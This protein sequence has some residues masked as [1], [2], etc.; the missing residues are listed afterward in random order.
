M[1]GFLLYCLAKTVHMNNTL[2]NTFL[3]FADLLTGRLLFIFS[4]LL[5]S[6]SIN[7]QCWQQVSRGPNHTLAIA[8]DGS[9]W[10]WGYNF[11]GQLGIGTTEK[12]AIPVKVG[13]GTQWKSVSAGVYHT[14]A[15]KNDGTLWAWGDNSIGTLGDSNYI[16]STIPIQIGTETNWTNICSGGIHSL[17]IK[18]N[19][20]LWGWGY[21]T[22]S[23]LTGGLSLLNKVPTQIGAETDWKSVVSDLTST[24][25]IKT[26]GTLWAWGDNTYGQLGLGDVF[27]PIIMIPAKV[28]IATDWHSVVTTR[29]VYL[30]LKTDST[31]WGW[32][33]NEY[34][35]LGQVSS[36]RSPVLLDT[37][38]QKWRSVAVGIC[39]F[40]VKNDGTLWVWGRNTSDG[41]IAMD[42]TV[43]F[44]SRP[45]RVGS[46]N[47]WQSVVTR[48]SSSVALTEGNSMFGWGPNF[49]GETGS[50]NFEQQHVP[51]PVSCS[52]P[53]PVHLITF[54]AVKQESSV[55]LNWATE[56]EMNSRGYRIERGKNGIDF[57]PIGM[58]VSKNSTRLNTY[59]FTDIHPVQGKNYYRLQMVDID[60]RFNYSDIRVINMESVG[61]TYVSLF[62]GP[63]K[64]LLYIKNSFSADRILVT[65]SD[66]LGR[67]LLVQTV[68]NNNIPAIS[69]AMLK[70][71]I[72]MVT[73]AG[74]NNSVT[75]KVVKQ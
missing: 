5:I 60:G 50:G 48:V 35:N 64:N 24:M 36:T 51:F 4:L 56:M 68:L 61:N 57:S 41:N 6:T 43:P 10:A 27:D 34:G 46:N 14:L 26:D 70:N 72:Y 19:G 53:L 1:N 3:H 17:A 62:P 47:N 67:K 32:G 38:G 73:V 55:L 39:S 63:V 69:M 74:N 31:L 12:S 59:T 52:G 58:V 22:Y 65:V 21:N 28:G 7:A 45:V 30:A 20:S 75:Q 33:S 37:T 2:R 42:T 71:G 66:M 44:I 11:N 25:G 23:Q 8:T 18:S 54:S 29:N 15:I 16:S 49:D 13:T 40:G 9:L